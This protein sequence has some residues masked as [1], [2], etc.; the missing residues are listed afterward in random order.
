MNREQALEAAMSAG[1]AAGNLLLEYSDDFLRTSTKESLRD[2]VTD[3]DKH[4]ERIIIEILK[5]NDSNTSILT[6]ESGRISASNENN[7]WI[8]DALDGTVNYVNHIPLYAV[9]I[10]LIEGNSLTVGVIYNPLASDL[11]YGAKGI[12]AYKNH[13]RIKVK[14][15]IPEESIFGVAFSGAKYQPETRSEEFLTLERVNDSTR[16]C[17]RTGSAAMNLAYLAEGRLSGCWGKANK[18]WDVA[19]GILLASLS[20]SITEYKCVDRE[21][22]LVSYIA[23][24]PSVWTFINEKVKLW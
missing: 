23:T 13:T 4:A 7:H 1:V 21:R 10:A 12:G 11:Y 20:G 3:V 2:I 6:E 22:N 24:V 9:S 8:V 17:L 5:S 19:A 18:T 16:G 14:D 15:R